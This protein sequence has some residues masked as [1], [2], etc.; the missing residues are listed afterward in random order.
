MCYYVASVNHLNQNS[1]FPFLIYQDIEEKELA[2]EIL[3][4]P[5]ETSRK[6]KFEAILELQQEHGGLIEPPKDNILFSR[7]SLQD[8]VNEQEQNNETTKED[9]SSGSS[10][11][12]HQRSKRGHRRNTHSG[13]T[14]T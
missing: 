1:K 4:C 5:L 14:D 11:Q 2:E 12:V 13:T 6:R 10:K 9:E 8:E 7:L 3:N